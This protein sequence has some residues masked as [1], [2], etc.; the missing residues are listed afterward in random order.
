MFI[1]QE[2]VKQA[3]FIYFEKQLLEYNKQETFSYAPLNLC[4]HQAW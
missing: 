4:K 2:K 3:M 1:V